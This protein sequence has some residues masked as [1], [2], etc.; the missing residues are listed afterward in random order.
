MP[1]AGAVSDQPSGRRQHEQ[2]LRMAYSRMVCQA[3]TLRAS[4][5]SST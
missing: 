4:V 3:G 5:F 1:W 2:S